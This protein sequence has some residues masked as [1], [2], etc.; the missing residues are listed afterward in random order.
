M[1]ALC[2]FQNDLRMSDQA[3]LRWL[4]D[5]ALPFAGVV[6]E[7]EKGSSFQKTFFWQSVESL[8]QKLSAHAVPLYVF[9]GNPI[10]VIPDLVEKNRIQVVVKNAS[11]NSLGEAE[12]EALKNLGISLQT[13]QDRTLLSLDRLPFPISHLPLVFT[14][15]RKQVEQNLEI[16]LPHPAPKKLLGFSLGTGMKFASAPPESPLPYEFHGSEDSGMARVEEFFGKTKSVLHYKNTRNGMIQRNDSSKFSPWL[17]TGALSARWIYQE[18]K[19]FETEYEAN[20]STYWIFFELLWRD[21][22]KFLA[23]KI[24]ARLFEARGLKDRNEAW[25]EDAEAWESWKSGSTASPFVNANMKELLQ[26]G[27]M[28]NRGRQ[29]VAS[30]LAKTLGV[31]WTL[32]A[33]YFEE[34]LLDFDRESNWGNW[35]YQSGMGT[36]PR[37]R[38]FDPERQARIY[39][40]EGAYQGLWLKPKREAP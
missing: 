32:G 22:F 24:G 16:P 8:R 23:K 2:W 25:I 15:F 31:E 29:N 21:Y 40:P 6:F 19:K 26:T 30:Y 4:A 7:P 17:A 18:L 39:D 37:D 27:W 1:R 36:D 28:S 35:L 38:K 13:M 10:Y 20:E 11:F 9:R 12:E 33:S 3:A 34:Q 14:D 5:A